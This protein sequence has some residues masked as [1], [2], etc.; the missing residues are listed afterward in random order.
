M[1]KYIEML[2]DTAVPISIQPTLSVSKYDAWIY[3]NSWFSG[4]NNC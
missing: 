3:N 4:P 1:Q 2:A